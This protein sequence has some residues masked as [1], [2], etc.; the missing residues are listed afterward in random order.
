MAA[1]IGRGRVD[2]VRLGIIERLVARA[3]VL[4]VHAGVAIAALVDRLLRGRDQRK[5]RCRYQGCRSLT[6][7][8][9]PAYAFF[10]FLLRHFKFLQISICLSDCKRKNMPLA[11]IETAE[12]QSKKH[13][14]NSNTKRY[15]G[16]L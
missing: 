6:E 10:A 1:C 16:A 11:V 7:K 2:R 15:L 14:G 13:F 8:L 4:L 3:K 12:F 9:P 5:T